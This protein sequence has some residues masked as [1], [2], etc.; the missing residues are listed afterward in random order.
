[1]RMGKPVGAFALLVMLV[2]ATTADADHSSSSGGL[3]GVIPNL[4][5]RGGVLLLPTATLAPGDTHEP[6]FSAS[7]EQQLTVIND[8]LRGQLSTLPLPSPASGFSFRFDPAVGALVRATESFGPI[9]SQRADTTGKNKITI[10]ASYSRF[11]FNTLDEQN[12]VDDG[13]KV[14]FLH[15]RPTPGCPPAGCPFERDTITA[16][17]KAEITSD[18]VL[19]SATYGVLEN[20]DLSIALPI[21]HTR[22]KAEGTATINH[23]SAAT[24]AVHAFANGT[25]SLTVK[26]TDDSTGVGDLVLRA[27]YNFWN[28]RY[29]H[30]AAGL[31]LQL[32][33]G[34]VDNLRGVG[35]PIVS[36]VFIAST[37]SFY[38][39]SPHVNVGLHLSTNTSKIEHEFFYNV[40]FDWSVFKPLTFAFDILGRY[41]IDNQ[42]IRAGQG[43]GGTDISGSN[44]VNASIGVKV[45]VWKDILG[46]ANVLLPINGTGLRDNATWLVGLEV[47]F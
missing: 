27:K 37:P 45:N 13:I 7:S 38:G 29:V 8:S 30:M 35:T 12:L 24:R 40:G 18:V 14:T 25:D 9:Y 44:I 10:G 17:I 43:P 19:L 6:H 42:R 36:P 28:A 15:D 47:A 21:I 20:L 2:C 4:F 11:T 33:S 5:G 26:D 16:R 32:P 3:A 23:I 39:V 31:D 22:I 41:I 46:V 34:S 1:M